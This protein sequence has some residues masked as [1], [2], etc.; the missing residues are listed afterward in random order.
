MSTKQQRV[1]DALVVPDEAEKF[2]N[3]DY[4]GVTR[5]V[6]QMI[7]N[8]N[9]EETLY[10]DILFSIICIMYREILYNGTEKK[11]FD[12]IGAVLDAEMLDAEM[13]DAEMLDAE[14][15]NASSSWF[16]SNSAFSDYNNSHF[17]SNIQASANLINMTL[18]KNTKFKINKVTQNV[19]DQISQPQNRRNLIDRFKGMYWESLQPP[20]KNYITD[21]YERFA[22]RME[23]VKRQIENPRYSKI[24]IEQASN[25]N[26][27]YRQYCKKQ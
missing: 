14:N 20:P 10:E 21:L 7:L 12:L 27:M 15:H 4:N 6:S 8:N 25:P 23:M 24:K 1:A 17:L 16:I 19:V 3:I 22:V 18:L 26:P 11:V 9:Q 13:L 5:L 2:F